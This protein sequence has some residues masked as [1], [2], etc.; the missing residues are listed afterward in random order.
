MSEH[1]KVKAGQ[2][3][4]PISLERSVDKTREDQTHPSVYTRNN[5][6]DGMADFSQYSGASE[7]F[8]A[9]AA[10]LPAPPDLSQEELKRVTNAGREDVARTEMQSLSSKVN[11]QDHMVSTRDGATLQARTYRPATKDSSVPLPVYL[12]FHG[13]GFFFG[14]LTSEDA[15]CSRIAIDVEVVV[16]NVN[17]RHTPEYKY[18]IPFYDSEDALDWTYR[19]AHKFGG[20]SSQI[21]VGGVSAG[22]L[23]TAS[24]MQTLQRHQSPA[25][26]SIRGQVLMIPLVVH[27]DCSAPYTSLLKDPKQSSYIE[28]EFA[29]VLPMTRLKFFNDLLFAQ[30]PD[31]ADRRANPGLA[32]TEELAQLPPATIGIA[33]LDPLRDDGLFYAKKLHEAG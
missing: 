23:L 17:Y 11:I 27:P 29:P 24:L 2:S 16:V 18:P 25:R 28:N 31:P 15:L 7:E 19:E 8:L 10:T 30:S 6:S 22:G 33:G 1:D 14:T 12:H 3:T 21:V 26:S 32:T 4:R 5:K 20:D 13:G 9:L